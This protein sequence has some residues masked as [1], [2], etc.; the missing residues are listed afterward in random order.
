ME[1][2]VNQLRLDLTNAP[3]WLF[4]GTT[5]KAQVARLADVGLTVLGE[6]SISHVFG[7]VTSRCA[8]C[9]DFTFSGGS[10]LGQEG[11]FSRFR[12][13]FDQPKNLF[14]IVAI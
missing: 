6:D 4:S 12:T 3:V 7:E 13:T 11:F 10:L 9:E 8:F 2:A 14:E 1:I 5:G